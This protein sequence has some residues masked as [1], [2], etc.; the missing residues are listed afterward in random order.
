MKIIKTGIKGY[1][2][3]IV[4]KDK[5][6]KYYGSGLVEVFATPAMI[7][8]MENTAL[9]SIDI[10]LQEGYSSVGI[11]ISVK[12][13]KATPLNAK[14]WCESIV[15]GVEGKKIFFSLKAYYDKGLIGEGTHTR[16]IINI[17]DF[18]N[19]LL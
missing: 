19:K 17:K 10:L 2:E 14:V 1:R 8:L 4:T 6:A 5:T 13:L 7:A 16:Y 12:H 15:T 3:E 11:D 9:H 18:M